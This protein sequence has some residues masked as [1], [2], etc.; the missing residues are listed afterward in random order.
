MFLKL[1]LQIGIYISLLACFSSPGEESSKALG[2]IQA[3]I[4]LANG[5]STT[6]TELPIYYKVTFDSKI[7]INSFTS[8][9]IQ[10]Y[11]T[12]TSVTFAVEATANP[13]VF[14]LRVV[15]AKTSGSIVPSLKAKSV[16]SK[17]KTRFNLSTSKGPTVTYTNTSRYTL[18]SDVNTY[19]SSSNAKVWAKQANK[20]LISASTASKGQEL[21]WF[22]HTTNTSSIL[23]DINPGNADSEI[24]DLKYINANQFVFISNTD[25]NGDELW[26]SDGTEAGTQKISAFNSETNGT[27]PPIRYERP[28]SSQMENWFYNRIFVHN[29]KAIIASNNNKLFSFDGSTLTEL[30][31][32]QTN[33]TYIGQ[34]NS[35]LLFTAKKVST[36]DDEYILTDGT[37]AGTSYHNLNASSSSADNDSQAISYNNKIYKS[38]YNQNTSNFDLFEFSDSTVS[39]FDDYVGIYAPVVIDNKFILAL[40]KTTQDAIV[41][42][43]STKTSSTLTMSILPTWFN[44]T[45]DSNFYTYAFGSFYSG[46]NEAKVGFYKFDKT[47]GSLLSEEILENSLYMGTDSICSYSFIHNDG[48]FIRVLTG[49]GNTKIEKENE[50]GDLEEIYTAEDSSTS[51]TSI[52][53]HSD[54]ILVL[55]I[56][57]NDD[58]TQNVYQLNLNTKAIQVISSIAAEQ[59]EENTFYVDTPNKIGDTYYLNLDME[60]G[61]ELFYL[62][63]NLDL[64]FTENFDN[65]LSASI[66]LSSKPHHY[67]N[68]I[69]ISSYSEHYKLNKTTYALNAIDTITPEAVGC[70]T[71]HI[72]NNKIYQQCYEDGAYAILGYINFED[73]SKDYVSYSDYNL[74][75]DWAGTHIVNN[76]LYFIA[77]ESSAGTEWRYTDFSSIDL[78][79][80]IVTGSGDGMHYI[81]NATVFK[82][83]L[84]F[85]RLSTG[86]YKNQIWLSDGSTAGTSLISNLDGYNYTYTSN[87]LEHNNKLYMIRPKV[88]DTDE[89]WHIDGT[90]FNISMNVST[91]VGLWIYPKFIGAAG[92]YILIQSQ[93]DID[94]DS[95]KSLYLINIATNSAPTLVASGVIILDKIQFDNNSFLISM[96]NAN[97]NTEIW[98]L[99][100]TNGNFSIL[101]EINADTNVGSNPNGFIK[102][103]SNIYFS[104]NDGIHGNELWISDGTSS[105]TEL[106]LDILEGEDSSYPTPVNLDSNYLT[107]IFSTINI[108]SN[109]YNY[110]LAP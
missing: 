22:D 66:S 76:K 49:N 89:I 57:N 7:V 106:Y 2:N 78:L 34:T 8:N 73:N 12:A 25:S 99:N 103:G 91:S 51:I 70:S 110:R 71:L 39:V 35:K 79:I 58:D 60:M 67:N 9:S 21:Y 32:D 45:F 42:N 14:N 100:G 101:K 68:S 82:D 47:S 6:T 27:I 53:A 64:H 74:S 107:V 65:S 40:E 48:S 55:S 59:T 20:I 69:L 13:K 29:S 52:F 105:G 108:G 19:E 24:I 94:E 92:D 37:L 54:N 33:V 46:V 11:G 3:K 62:D 72:I 109:L 83:K 15:S 41:Y 23:K 43:M 90:S 28:T 30:I 38:I 5:Q 10:Q 104:A 31:D 98:K 16:F 18:L 84:V 81:G 36:D 96:S 88:G 102:I 75:T 4:E 17:G 85:N 95:E 63:N 80:D 86:D 26:V 1:L 97:A 77:D 93:A 87:Y 44:C 61:S 56:Y 50:D